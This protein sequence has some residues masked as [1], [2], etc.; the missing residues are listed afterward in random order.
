MLQLCQKHSCKKVPG[1]TVCRL[2]HPHHPPIHTCL[3]C[4][5]VRSL[6]PPLPRLAAL[7]AGVE[8]DPDVVAEEARMKDLLQHR[9]GGWRGGVCG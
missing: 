3:T 2:A 9:T 1:M 8:R 5:G 6:N 4:R 7:D